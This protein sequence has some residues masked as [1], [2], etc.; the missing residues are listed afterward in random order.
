LDSLNG[1]A[2]TV[3]GRDFRRLGRLSGPFDLL[4]QYALPRADRTADLPLGG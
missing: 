2:R 1:V 4:E 3:A